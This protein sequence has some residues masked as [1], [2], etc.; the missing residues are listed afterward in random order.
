M[1]LFIANALKHRCL[2]SA[3]ICCFN[4]ALNCLK[5]TRFV[6]NRCL[7][8]QLLKRKSKINLFHSATEVSKFS[9]V[10]NVATLRSFHTT[11]VNRI[12]AFVAF[13]LRPLGN[14]IA[15]IV[16]RRIR[17]WWRN[18]PPDKRQAF[19]KWVIANKLRL[20]LYLSAFI[21]L[22]YVY[23]HSHVEETPL[24][25]RKRFVIFS[26]QQFNELAEYE[27]KMYLTQFNERLLPVNHPD[28]KR[29]EKVAN[30]LLKANLDIK[31]IYEKKWSITVV[32][33]PEIKN[34]FVL[35]SGRI[36]VFTGI[37]NI[38]S[39]DDQLGNVIAHEMSH[40]ILGHGA[41][42][43]S[44]AQFFE[45][46]AICA[47]GLL[48]AIVPF[49]AS[50]AFMTWFF[51]KIMDIAVHLPY[52][53]QLEQEA[54]VVGLQIAAKACF[55]IREAVVFWRKMSL[56]DKVEIEAMF[57][58]TETPN[59]EFLSS[60][61]SHETRAENIESLLPVFLQLREKCNCPKLPLLDPRDRFEQQKKEFERKLK[62][63]TAKIIELSIPKRPPGV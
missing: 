35:P 33:A 63:K 47:I 24:T 49:D 18:L 39:N 4:N 41:E 9:I 25:K 37:L 23:Y 55:D 51:R 21:S 2:Q 20:T 16:G 19:K 29:V 17:N 58:T 36:F 28:C 54:D 27:H 11:R 43:L 26:P 61:P 45:V 22:A 60:H 44:R 30:R 48:W 46:F 5:S 1:A 40:A 52:N 50:A 15:V 53:R 6:S 59:I 8:T 13:I 34:A 31:E 42:L 62:E 32:N 38:T 12:P 14:I 56:K 7:Q 10:E 3:R 57:G